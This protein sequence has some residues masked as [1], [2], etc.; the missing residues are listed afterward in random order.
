MAMNT[1]NSPGIS[2]RTNVY[3]AL[4][5]LDHAEPVLILQKFADAKSI[6]KNSSETVS[7]R[8]PIPFTVST[9]ELVEGV[10]PPSS[11]FNYENVEATVSQ[12]GGWSAITDKVA[13]MHEDPVLKDISM[14]F[15]ENAAETKEIVLWDTIKG[16][17]VRFF[18]SSSHSSRA[19]V[20]D[21]ATIA[22]TSNHVLSTS[23][24]RAIV[25][26]LKDQ[27]TKKVTKILSASPKIATEPVNA[28]YVA[29]GHTDLEPDIRDMTGFVPVEKYG[30][31]QPI[32]DYEVGKVEEVR[33]ILSPLFTPLEGVGST[34]A[35]GLAAFMSNGASV[36][37]YQVV[38]FGQK[39]FGDVALK[40]P[41]AIQMHVENPGNPNPADKLGQRG[42][43][44]WK[45]YCTPIRLNESW[46][47]RWEVAA[48]SL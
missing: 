30:T 38:V 16:G 37:V 40:G 10:T 21:L 23:R 44:S 47:A 28:A 17:T 2:Q 41:K 9:A 22:G 8:R 25:R 15:G 46:M 13:D 14:M 7:F 27:R 24:Q 34:D 26:Y 1:Y 35:G 43:A 29:V 48:T 31:F 6:P 42:F 36:N 33:Y 39:A 32:S 20:G 19:N 18:P 12:Y 5:A 11:S 3:A 45:T 4:E